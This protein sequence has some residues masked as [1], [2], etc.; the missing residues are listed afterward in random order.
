VIEGI[1]YGAVKETFRLLGNA[2]CEVRILNHQPEKWKT[3]KHTT[4]GYFDNADALEGALK[5]LKGEASAIYI[6]INELD[7]GCLARAYNRFELKTN[8]TTSNNAVSRRKWLLVDVDPTRVSGVSSSDE[9][10]AEAADVAK[11]IFDYLKEKGFDRCIKCDSSNG[12]HILYPIDLPNDKESEALIKRFLGV[13]GDRFDN[14][15]ASID[16]TVFSAGQITKLYG[17]T[18]K[19]GDSMPDRPHRPSRV[20][21][22]VGSVGEPI[23]VECIEAVSGKEEKRPEVIKK[24]T[25]KP[26]GF[27]LSEFL[28][29]NG[30]EHKP[31]SMAGYQEAYLIKECPFDSSHNRWE[32]HVGQME[33]GRYAFKCQHNSCE[34]NG[35]KEFRAHYEPQYQKAVGG[36]KVVS[37]SPVAEEQQRVS[38]DDESGDAISEINKEYAL[39]LN[40]DKVV[41]TREMLNEIGEPEFRFMAVAAFHQYMANVLIWAG[42]KQYNA[43]Q[44]WMKS[45][46]RRT[47]DGVTFDPSHKAPDRYLNLWRG[48]AVGVCESGSWDLLKGHLLDNV[49]N[50][51]EEHYKYLMAW[52]AQMI[53]QPGEKPGVMMVLRGEKGVGKSILS[54]ILHLI[55]GSHSVK[56]S[57][58][59]HLTGNFNSHMA[60]K[61]LLR[62]EEGYWAG[63]KSADGPLKDL[64]TSD[65]VLIEKKGHDPIP[66]RNCIRVLMT[67]N[68]KWVVP[69]TKDERRYCVFDVA[70]NKRQDRKYFGAIWDEMH[71][72]GLER[73]LFDLMHH[74]FSDVDVWDAPETEALKEQKVESFDSVEQWWYEALCSEYFGRGWDMEGRNQ[75]EEYWNDRDIMKR[76]N[77]HLFYIDYCQK[78]KIKYP[79]SPQSF[80]RKLYKM[81]PGI[82]HKGVRASAAGRPW[83]LRLPAI[84]EA[85]K[86][87]DK[88]CNF[89]HDWEM[90]EF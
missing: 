4:A 28:S 68:N 81:C 55:Y 82:V 74:D 71:S 27:S 69:A 87:F 16:R 88:W 80:L 23:G 14:A 17:T 7:N 3:F 2:S 67:T 89:D 48:F 35:W 59:R 49:C 46:K 43:S 63:D 5:E 83:G 84:T 8:L 9:E 90:D 39:V 13:I 12:Y 30:I 21:E 32:M 15:S 20:L 11:L 22:V 19:K 41:I 70:S 51:N 64:I 42:D 57:Q 45:P 73:M 56:I 50:G 34:A 77:F 58:A 38:I 1:D 66:V 24:L 36:G 10:K 86:M 37:F 31:K 62:V 78:M 29:R 54:D 79:E 40:G 33:D 85:R 47:Y 72:G 26:G 53:Q 6:T 65:T 61:V 18:S 60:G 75:T 76:S 25:P 44:L 52:L